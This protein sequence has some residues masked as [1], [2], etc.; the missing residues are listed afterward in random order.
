MRI[1]LDLNVKTIYKTAIVCWSAVISNVLHPW[2][3]QY[4]LYGVM[5]SKQSVLGKQ[6]Y[7]W[8]KVK[9][10]QSVFPK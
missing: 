4:F 10:L 2:Q 6:V 9:P 8:Y 1:K 3:F 5:F 7:R